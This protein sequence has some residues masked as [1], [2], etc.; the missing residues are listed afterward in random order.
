MSKKRLFIFALAVAL[1]LSFTVALTHIT[2]T[3]GEETLSAIK[4]EASGV[5]FLDGAQLRVD[6][7][8]D[9]ITS[10]RFEAVIDSEL[11][12]LLISGGS[13]IDGAEMGFAIVPEFAFEQFDES[14]GYTDYFKYFESLGN[15]KDKISSV[16]KP[17]E[18]YPYKQVANADGTITYTKYI[19]RAVITLKEEHYA[20]KYRAFVYYVLNG[21]TY[22]SGLS[23]SRSVVCV[24][25]AVLDNAE[26]RA[27]LTEKQIAKLEKITQTYDA[28]SGHILGEDGKCEICGREGLS[29]NKSFTY[30]YLQADADGTTKNTKTLVAT[31]WN[32]TATVAWASSDNNI[33]T[34]ENGVI[35]RLSK[36]SATIT[37]S[38]N[39]IEKKCTVYV[40]DT[41]SSYKL[42]KGNQTDYKDSTKRDS[43]LGVWT[44][45]NSAG[46]GNINDGDLNVNLKSVIASSINKFMFRFLTFDTEFTA[47]YTVKTLLG[48]ITLV[49]TGSTNSIDISAVQAKAG[50]TVTTTVKI[51]FKN[52]YYWQI[53][54]YNNTAGETVTISNIVITPIA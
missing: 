38:V 19:A 27:K 21:E 9:G 23:V 35:K 31:V 10:V 50:Y 13:Y 44:N 12:D 42:Q 14:T 16:I 49:D 17:S 51:D 53:G 3:A 32:K 45:G 54:F 33:V 7:E 26:Y 25:G 47:T 40:V 43:F 30:L 6:E 2:A 36:G 5:G 28:E 29:L 4:N 22:Y 46:W 34:V 15:T 1:T 24:A 11:Y 48:G 41:A 20:W 39:G 18:I 8:D 52:N 37:A